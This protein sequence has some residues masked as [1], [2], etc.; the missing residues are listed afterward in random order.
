MTDA[1][2]S[3]AAPSSLAP[4][5]AML[6]PIRASR[7]AIANQGVFV[8]TQSL[9]DALELCDLHA[10]MRGAFVCDRHACRAR[11]QSAA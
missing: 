9:E 10:M 11:C 1:A 5:T 4:L 2:V 6:P 3:R 7:S 8:Q